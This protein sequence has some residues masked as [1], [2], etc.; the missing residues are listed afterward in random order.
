MTERFPVLGFR[1]A[2]CWQP[3]VIARHEHRA[4]AY[5]SADLW[6]AQHDAAVA[7]TNLQTEESDWRGVGW[8]PLGIEET[9]WQAVTQKIFTFVYQER[10]TRR[11]A[12]AVEPETT[13]VVKKLV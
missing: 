10:E 2:T 3:S 13:Q 5:G 8:A 12:R 1:E 11:P 4:D 7:I 6:L 9:V